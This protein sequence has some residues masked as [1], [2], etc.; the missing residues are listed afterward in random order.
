MRIR[1]MHV[2]LGCYPS[3]SKTLPGC[4]GGV[5][6]LNYIFLNSYVIIC[7]DAEALVTW[8][9]C[10]WYQLG[11]ERKGETGRFDWL[12]HPLGTPSLWTEKEG[13]PLWPHSLH[14]Y[15][16]GVAGVR[17]QRGSKDT[18]S[19][20][21][22]A[23]LFSVSGP[24]IGGFFACLFCFC[25]S[26]LWSPS[27]YSP[28]VQTLSSSWGVPDRESKTQKANKHCSLVIPRILVIFCLSTIFYL[29]VLRGPQHSA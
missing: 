24:S 4:V 17:K 29:L 11:A 19:P 10:P 27:A 3:G 26:S 28:V 14:H 9:Y 7:Q 20:L 5:I 13:S 25:F 6:F 22:L 2:Q 21:S 1:S 18:A 12:P 8:L 23:V 16:Q 15:C